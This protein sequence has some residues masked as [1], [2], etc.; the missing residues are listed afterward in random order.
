MTN[1]DS[2]LDALHIFLTQ[3]MGL[4]PEPM[5]S[6]SWR[7]YFHKEI[8]WHPAATTRTVKVLLD[9]TGMPFKI[10]LCVSSDNNNSV[11]M[12]PPFN[13]DD[14][15]TRIANEIELIKG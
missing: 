4:L 12:L 11:F 13:H 3:E 14:L 15:K 1:I 2:S 10:Q 7:T 9:H 8:I 5:H 6:G